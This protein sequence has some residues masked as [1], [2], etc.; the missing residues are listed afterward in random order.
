M[1]NRQ[2]VK[3]ATL[4]LGILVI[5][6]AG[7]IGW[8][9]DGAALVSQ[10]SGQAEA[11]QRNATQLAQ[12]YQEAMDYL[13]PLM[14]A[15]N[16][17]SRYNY[18]IMLQNMSSYASRPGAEAE[19]QAL[20]KVII[21]TV[22]QKEMPDT[23]REWCVR[24]LSR[25]GGAEAL[26][27]LTKLMSSDDKNLRDYARQALEKN[28]APGATDVLLKELA[29]AKDNAWKIGLIYS[30]GMRRAA[31]A[32]TPIAASLNDSDMAV[33]QAAI[34][35]LAEIGDQ[36]SI[37]ALSG[38]LESPDPLRSSKAA[39]GLVYVAQRMVK[40]GDN[41][42]AARLFSMLNSW[43]A[44]KGDASTFSVRVASIT[45]LA[46]CDPDGATD[47]IAALIRNP[48]PKLRA[49]AIEA[50]RR[51]P[52][53]APVQ[54]LARMLPDLDAASQAQVLVLLGE[55]GDPGSIGAIKGFLASSNPTVSMA[56]IDALAQIGT[57]A[58]AEALMTLVNNSSRTVQQAALAGLAIMPGA[59]VS[60]YIDTQARQA[61]GQDRV[62]AITLI[63]QRGEDGA[64]DKLLGYAEETDS[65]IQGAAFDALA[66][67][68]AD[69]DVQA[70]ADL[71]TEVKSSSVRAKAT[72]ALKAALAEA[73]DKDAAAETIAAR[74]ETADPEAKVALLT[75][76]SS[77]GGAEALGVVV[78]MTRSSD[79]TLRDAAIRTLCAWPDYEAA[80]LLLDIAAD[81][82]TSLTHHV[83][84]IR[85]GLRLIS[86]ADPTVVS[87]QTELCM[88]ALKVARRDAEK[89]QVVAALGTLGSQ[90][91]ADC[92]V[93]LASEGTLRNE[94]ALAA[95]QCAS[96]MMRSNRQAAMAVAQKIRDMDISETINTQADSLISGRGGRGMGMG[97]GMMRG[98]AGTRQMMN[99]GT[100]MR[101]GG[102]GMRQGG[103]DTRGRRGQ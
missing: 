98:G 84:A 29:A 26:P 5:L 19:R 12:A 17:A 56:A 30:L 53:A 20:A 41:A 52:S 3:M 92:L 42:D 27:L 32:V 93:E 7:S 78:G 81:D 59:D 9:Q 96:G 86:S 71:V 87:D 64:A 76:L 35:A 95:I 66:M 74:M 44:R 57:V 73:E 1:S 62:T 82:Q 36:N 51:S 10:L 25:M 103:T 2:S 77:L 13:L 90:A 60:A 80:P 40:D 100:G 69:V 54:M 48:N 72:A 22:E 37:R 18:Q 49:A 11:P 6:T 88:R 21:Q 70:L 61:Q 63:G 75:S 14:S 4:G 31:A 15:D 97:M 102:A 89:Q 65:D 16:V 46:V 8:A 39:Q 47:Q 43:A 33:T 91:A 68:A 101:Q 24:Q 94:A 83:L 55:R 38:V 79:E 28:P 85:G 45:G 99:R 34:A 67:V 58:S 23:V 50:A